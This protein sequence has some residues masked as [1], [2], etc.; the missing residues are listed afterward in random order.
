MDGVWIADLL[1]LDPR[2]RAWASLDDMPTP[3]AYAGKAHMHAE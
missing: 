1:M 2:T 3:V